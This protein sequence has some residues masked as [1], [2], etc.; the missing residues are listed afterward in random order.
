VGQGT[1]WG[2]SEFRAAVVVVL[3]GGHGDHGQGGRGRVGERDRMK[4]GGRTAEGRKRGRRDRE[5]DDEERKRKEEGPEPEFL[6]SRETGG[7]FPYGTPGIHL[8]LE[9][10][11]GLQVT[12]RVRQSAAGW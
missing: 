6:N 10:P 12:P 11:F 7:A 4:G 9:K 8:F 2:R 1:R 5:R 3:D